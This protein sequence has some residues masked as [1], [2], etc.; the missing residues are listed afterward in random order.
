MYSVSLCVVFGPSQNLGL[1][2]LFFFRDEVMNAERR[3]VRTQGY[4][5]TNR[6]P[7]MLRGKE[8]TPT[9]PSH[10]PREIARGRDA[11]ACQDN[12]NYELLISFEALKC[13]YIYIYIFL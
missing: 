10:P 8:G 3:L 4:T 5:D 6:T 2:L 11:E 12:H 7:G 1:K 13:Q 9:T